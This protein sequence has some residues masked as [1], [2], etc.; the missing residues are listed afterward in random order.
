[1]SLDTSAALVLLPQSTARLW[2]L[3]SRDFPQRDTVLRSDAGCRSQRH[4]L[5]LQRI[6][7]ILVLVLVVLSGLLLVSV[8]ETTQDNWPW[9]LSLHIQAI[10]SLP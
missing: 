3:E 10:F 5:Q 1:M 2:I 7:Q 8:T 9:S 6:V 4:R